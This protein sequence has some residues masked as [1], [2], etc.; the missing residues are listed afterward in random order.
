M[1]WRYCPAGV[2]GMVLGI[3]V[4]LSAIPLSTPPDFLGPH[5]AGVLGRLFPVGSDHVGRRR[6]VS[7]GS[8]YS[9]SKKRVG[10][11]SER[12]PLL[13]LAFQSEKR[14]GVGSERCPLIGQA[15]RSETGSLFRPIVRY[16][17]RPKS[18]AS[19]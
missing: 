4:D 11:G 10:V 19:L 14:V 12:R 2:Q 9:R 8:A 1:V 6:A 7:R 13:G 18:R 5:R 3:A 15:F 16:L 17:G